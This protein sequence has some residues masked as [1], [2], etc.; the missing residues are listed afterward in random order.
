MSSGKRS[1]MGRF[2]GRASESPEDRAARKA[3]RISLRERFT[4]AYRQ[5]FGKRVARRGIGAEV[6]YALHPLDAPHPRGFLRVRLDDKRHDLPVRE[7][8]VLGNPERTYELVRAGH[9][10]GARVRR[11]KRYDGGRDAGRGT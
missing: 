1:L 4:E 7:R 6:H 10:E 11:A 2:F 3:E 5:L 8:P 9:G